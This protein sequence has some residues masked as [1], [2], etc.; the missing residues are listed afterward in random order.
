MGLLGRK[1]ASFFMTYD[2]VS[3]AETVWITPTPTPSIQI[4]LNRKKRL[5]Y[6][7][8][9]SLD[10]TVSYSGSYAMSSSNVMKSSSIN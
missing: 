9:L 5:Y 4:F 10:D 8:E 7:S 2:V 6:Q 1:G 3:V